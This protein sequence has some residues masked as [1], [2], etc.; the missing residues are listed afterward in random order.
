MNQTNILR[1]YSIGVRITA[2]IILLMFAIAGLV[3][4][5]VY[6]GDSVKNSGITDA[7]QVMMDG[8]K[9]KLKLGTHTIATA[10]GKAL[11]GV[12]EPE[13]QARIISDYI[14][15]IRFEDDRSGYYFV[16]RGTVVFVHPIQPNIVG[17]NL[18]NTK[19]DNGVY[20]VSELNRVAQQ[21][22]GFVEY[23]FGKPQP[24]GRVENAP[25]LAYSEMISGTDLW[26]STGIY[27]DNIE[28]LKE[29]MDER[30]SGQLLNRLLVVIGCIV[31]LSLLV[32]LPLCLM[33]VKSISVPLRRTTQAAEQ[34]ANGDLDVQLDA[35]GK[36]EVSVLQQSLMRMVQN[37]HA[38]FSAIRVKEA[39]ALA[40]AAEA[41]KAVLQAREASR[42]A[43]AANAGM[44]QAALRLEEAA[45]EM[46]A[47]A[48]NIS[49]STSGVKDGTAV[50]DTRIREI[51]T[52]IEQLSASVLDIA[53]SA[54][55][56]AQQ[57]EES[58]LKVEASAGLAVE[59]GKAMN[60]LHE[61]TGTLTGNIHKLGEQSESIGEV[62]GVINDIADQTNLL[63]LNAAIE[64]ARA[65]DA[66]RGF[67]VVADEVRKL[68]EKT[69]QAT[70]QVRESI[71]SIQ[72]L[73]KVN[74]SGMD[75]AVASMQRVSGLSAE[76]VN[77]LNSV[78]VTVKEATAQVQAIA[79][80]VEQQSASSSEV[81]TLVGE[82]S[83]IASGNSELVAKADSDLRSLARKAGGLLDLVAE[84]RK[85]NTE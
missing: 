32:L 64:A 8:E 7:Q 18:G 82:V 40:K 53:R 46:E 26:I 75:N 38:S 2:I 44:M 81:A 20:Y 9:A 22:G 4:A 27:I 79:A 21:G 3:G 70:H 5:I 43:D 71:T 52:A 69:M 80:A 78:Q 35:L 73:T 24:G 25:K 47:F 28:K 68:A 77:A 83:H 84:L 6:T 76:T 65:G 50:Q 58:R 62:M 29:S 85:A 31:A 39:E 10:L 45:H 61:L 55:T 1:N 56:A 37:L 59:S 23:I 30:M 60:E 11:Q 66:G 48:D 72:H 17:K 42:K 12:T 16:Y 51:L 54:S 41:E 57:S 19:D 34:I 14:N 74:I 15:D 63:A 13:E 49:R 33:T 67:A 36:D